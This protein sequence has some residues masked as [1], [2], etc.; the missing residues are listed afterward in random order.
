M[1]RFSD[2]IRGAIYMM[3]SMAGFIVSDSIMKLVAP[4]LPFFQ[5][6][7]LRGSMAALLI[8]LLAWHHGV[9]SYRP[10]RGDS[11]LMGMRTIGEVA[12]M[13]CLLKALIN[14]PIVN[15]TAIVQAIPLVVTLGAAFLFGER[16]GWQRYLAILIGLLG[17]LAIVRPGGDGFTIYSLWAVGTVFFF[18]LRDLSTRQLSS[19]APSI[20]AALVTS[21]AIVLVS[22]LMSLISPWQPVSGTALKLLAVAGCC[23][24][25][26]YLF[27]VMTMRVGDVGFIAP[28]RYSILIWALLLG[29]LMFGEFP[30][31]M[32]IFGSAVIVG[33]GLYAVSRERRIVRKPLTEAG[34][35]IQS[36]SALN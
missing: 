24:V 35:D 16:V 4:D 5:M 17:V 33:M 28:F 6:I 2:N 31:R 12:G 18:T 13:I 27:S 20:F 29:I 26:G 15:A 19:A 21:I 7:F 1:V 34:R 14:I 8:G 25:V 30:D 9:L 3:V 36:E 11:K 10:S 23:T 32:T 22:G